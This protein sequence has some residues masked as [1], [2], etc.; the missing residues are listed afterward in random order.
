MKALAFKKITLDGHDHYLPTDIKL[1]VPASTK[2]APSRRHLLTFI[3]WDNKFLTKVDPDYRDFFKYVLPHLFPR[4]T[5]V[6]TAVS[7][8]FVPELIMGIDPA[9]DYHLATIGVI[10]HDT[11]WSKVPEEMIADSLDY[12]GVIFTPSAAEAKRLHT[13]YGGELAAELLHGYRFKHPLREADIRLV[14]NIARY[15]ERPLDF[16]VHGHTPSEC[17]VVCEADHLWPF[18][19]ENFWLDVVRKGVEPGQYVQNVATSIEGLF[20]TPTGKRIAFRLLEQRITEVA[21]YEN[22]VAALTEH[23]HQFTPAPA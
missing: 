17:L 15:H 2:V 4:T 9:T 23:R 18:T 7:L 14:S 13:V 20:L 12:S 19:H 22:Y 3:P 10:L 11:G 1:A 5:N 16:K 21:A 6:H 8:S